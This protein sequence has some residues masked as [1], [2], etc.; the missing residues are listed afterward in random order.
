MKPAHAGGL[1]VRQHISRRFIHAYMNQ[2]NIAYKGFIALALAAIICSSY[3]VSE[4]SAAEFHDVKYFFDNLETFRSDIPRSGIAER[5]T[6]RGRV[7]THMLPARCVKAPCPPVKAFF[8]QDVNDENYRFHMFGGN[9]LLR[10]LK[11]GNVYVLDGL[12]EKSVD[13]GR[14]TVFIS[15]FKPETILR[16]DVKTPSNTN[17]SAFRRSSAV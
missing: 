5:V 9:A 16:G 12:L 4:A 11:L 10:R 6:V 13:V 8:L 17:V 3:F 2:P 1:Y 7:V 14:K 15:N